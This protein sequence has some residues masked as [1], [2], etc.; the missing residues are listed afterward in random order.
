MDKFV[1]DYNKREYVTVQFLID[2]DFTYEQ[3][4]AITGTDRRFKDDV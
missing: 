2:F 3:L 1:E 4:N